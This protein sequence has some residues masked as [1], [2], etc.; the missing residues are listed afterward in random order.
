MEQIPRRKFSPSTL[1]AGSRSRPAP[2]AAPRLPGCSPSLRAS[3]GQPGLGRSPNTSP[4]PNFN[5]YFN[6]RRRLGRRREVPPGSSRRAAAAERP[7]PPGVPRAVL[8]AQAPH[9][10]G[11]AGPAAGAASRP[12]G[13]QPLEGGGGGGVAF[14]L[15]SSPFPAPRRG[16]RWLRGGLRPLGSAPRRGGGRTGAGGLAPPPPL[17]WPPGAEPPATWKRAPGGTAPSHLAA[18][19][20]A[21]RAGWG[22]GEGRG[23]AHGRGWGWGGAVC[24]VLERGWC[25]GSP[26]SKA[27]SCMNGASGVPCTECLNGRPKSDPNLIRYETCSRE[28]ALVLQSASLARLVRSVCCKLSKTQSTFKSPSRFFQS[29]TFSLIFRYPA[30]F[31]AAFKNLNSKRAE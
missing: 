29:K 7:G 26:L 11:P 31:V 1:P 27:V 21:E 10:R 17:E 18:V 4:P 16:K 24:G 28:V 14:V 2:P 6:S 22:V 12:A 23:C 20:R 30:F 15:P 3:L 25:E 9:L 19:R 13:R 5:P 8:G